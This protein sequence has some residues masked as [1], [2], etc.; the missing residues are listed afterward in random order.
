MNSRKPPR[1]PGVADILREVGTR[2][3]ASLE[4]VQQFI[5]RRMMEYNDTP[6]PDLG[7]FSP[8]DVHALIYGDWR[9][10]G[11]LRLQTTLM[12]EELAGSGFYRVSRAILARLSHD[13]VKLTQAGFL[14]G[15]VLRDL[16]REPGLLSPGPA[17]AILTPARISE[18]EIEAIH[19]PRVT[20]ELAGLVGKRTGRLTLRR[21][22][23][24]FLQPGTEGSLFALLFETFFR[25][26]NLAYA[27]RGPDLP[28]FQHLI[29]YAIARLRS[30]ARDWASDQVVRSEAIHPDL[31]LELPNLPDYDPVVGITC[32]RLL[33]PLVQFGLL[34]ERFVPDAK[35]WPHQWQVRKTPLF[36]HFLPA[37]AGGS[38]PPGLTAESRRP[39][40]IRI[41]RPP[42]KMTVRRVPQGSWEAGDSRVGGTI[43]QRLALLSTLSLS[44][45]AN[46]G[47]A[48]PSY[49]REDMPMCRTPLSA[50][51][52]RD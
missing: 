28:P 47:R 12:A 43:N 13:P 38:G 48:L 49:R 9:T 21:A 8:S 32:T 52:D 26:L 20:L 6:Q 29:G 42:R 39:G 1:P 2:E 37:V 31:H 51:R 19:L 45:W 22:G 3:W 23:R 24:R 16:A 30:V 4:Q 33:R 11:P 36:D 7:G 17:T 34:E 27:G 44:T 40:Y 41:M 25:K 14:P 18:S 35:T 15:V 50:R 5:D 10:A 46:S